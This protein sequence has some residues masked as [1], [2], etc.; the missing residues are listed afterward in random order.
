MPRTAKRRWN[1]VLSLSLL[2]LL[3]ALFI[4]TPVAAQKVSGGRLPTRWDRSV[5]RTAPLPDYPRPQMARD[6]WR[7]LNG[8]WDEAITDKAATA[9][10][11]AYDG[12]ILV[13]F[14]VESA[15]SGVAKA[16]APSRRLWYHREFTVPPKWSTKNQ[17]VLLHFG[18][19][20]W[21][22][23]VLVNGKSMG[24]HRGGYD[25]FDFDITDALKAGPNDLTVSVVD[26]TDAGQQPIGKQRLNP[27][28][29]F[30]TA[31]TGIWQ[32]VWI[33]PV[34]AVHIT[35]LT[36]TPDVDHSILHLRVQ[37]EGASKG[38][39]IEAI[40]TD[41]SH[42]IAD[43]TGPLNEEMPVPIIGQHL[44]SPSDPH[45]YGLSVF[46]L[47]KEKPT[48]AVDSYFAMR[49]LSLGK[50]AQG[51]T[52]LFLNNRFVFQA[53]VLDQGY[54]PDGVY[55]APTDAALR[56]DI[57]AAKKLGF[58]MIRKHAKVEPDRWYTWAD[59]LGMLVWQDMPQSFSDH[60]SPEASEQFD[61]ELRRLIA[62]RCNHPS[63]VTWV[64]FNE[65][66]GQH[67]TDRIVALIKQLDPTRFVDPA[68]GW[69]DVAGLGDMHD[70]HHYP[71][72]ASPRP[73]PTRAAVLGEFGGLGMRVDGH[74]WDQKSWGYQG[75]FSN[76]WQLTRRYQRYLQDAY[77]LA[78]NPGLSA[79]VYTQLTDVETESNGLFTYDRAVV[80]P[81]AEIIAAA[82]QGDFRR[83]PPNPNPDLVP[84]A[85]EE[86]VVW[87]YTTEK[88]AEDWDRPDFNA[89]GW[90]SGPAPFGHEVG[91][92]RTLWNTSDIWLRRE[93]VP[94]PR[95]PE[96]LA[97]LTF[98]DEDVEIY[99]NGVLAA[100]ATGYVGDY[101]LLPMNAA[102]R[103]ALKPGKNLIAVHCHQTT[104]GQYIDVGITKASK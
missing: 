31:C 50:D 27:G 94:P 32:S 52:R 25:G 33:E 69:N 79:V 22:A 29:I 85:Q 51:R 78:D 83:L 98:H 96:R 102:G 20:D 1:P 104:G 8:L 43:T 93:V 2:S 53:G 40:V 68:S 46:L 9:P 91:E 63:I 88:P 95:L 12:K 19:V 3:T 38:L 6:E 56:S 24:M 48:D 71:A 47:Q 45:L 74:M 62:G 92:P 57:E 18:A 39:R 26:P 16:V 77:R 17:R 55:T 21:E 11:A 35:G 13:P 30:Y 75:L 10:P 37:A 67:E 54:W 66:W 90:K 41:G 42:R 28:G 7:S 89:G 70:W 87:Q 81:D 64:A 97:F 103:A 60:L 4:V 14:P 84:T 59:R 82:N 44:W 5:S 61:T 99:I 76:S 49:K 23:A 86:P 58:N 73:E 15:L 101:V 72:P 100:S 65:G 34:P 80:K 36:F